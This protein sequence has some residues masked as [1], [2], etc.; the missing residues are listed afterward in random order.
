MAH[1]RGGYQHDFEIEHRIAA[2]RVSRQ[3][4]EHHCCEPFE[5]V[6]REDRERRAPAERAQRVRS[7]GV[8]TAVF[9]HVDAVETFADPYRARYRSQQVSDDNQ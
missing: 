9:A 6:D 5:D 4:G 7:P 1:Y 2:R 3:V 8:V